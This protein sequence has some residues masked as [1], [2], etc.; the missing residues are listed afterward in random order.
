[1][2]FATGLI[3]VAF[4]VASVP[5]ESTNTQ[6][7][8]PKTLN[9][10][11]PTMIREPRIP[12]D[13]QKELEPLSGWKDVSIDPRTL[14]TQNPAYVNGL[15]PQV[16]IKDHRKLDTT[17]T[18][19]IDPK[20]LSTVNPEGLGGLGPQQPAG[21]N[22]ELKKA[23]D[24]LA[25]STN[26]GNYHTIDPHS[27]PTQ[28]PTFVEGPRRG[29]TIPNCSQVYPDVYEPVCGT[30]GVTYSNSCDLGIASSKNPD[31]KIAKRSD[32]RC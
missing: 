25:G 30:D 6:T 29:N 12:V 4:A 2:K 3:V 21:D 11:D 7:L 18:L 15:G 10:V 19:T 24:E 27:L 1:M 28:D 22:P 32:G 31:K 17:N 23:M 20:S 13:K 9:Y 26:G 8:D 5:A 14:P 16:P